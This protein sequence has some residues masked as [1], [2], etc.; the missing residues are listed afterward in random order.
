MRSIIIV[1]CSVAAVS[2][3]AGSAAWPP[4]PVVDASPG[5]TQTG[6]ASWYGPGFNGKQTAS[7]EVYDMEAMTAAHRSLPFQ[8]RVRVENLDNGAT[9]E[10]RINDRGPFVRGRIIDLSKA[11]ARRVDMLG[12]GTARVRI[13]V[14]GS[15]NVVTCSRLQL[16]AFKDRANAVDLSK[17][18]RQ[19][20]TEI[21]VET[22]DDGLHRVFAGPYP[23]RTA[24]ERARDR[25]GGTLLAC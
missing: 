13:T 16:G 18:V 19:R 20:R 4:E 14:V 8:A 1:A 9:T 10:V 7:G 3:C 5:W 24:G 23:S 17:R 6:R 15:G 2:A 25:L 21:V 12:S 22:G 11:A